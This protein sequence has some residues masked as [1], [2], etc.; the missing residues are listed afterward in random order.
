MRPKKYPYSG[1]RK[2]QTKSANVVTPDLVIFPNISIRKE[3]LKHVYT[4]IKNV[5][6]TTNIYFRIPKPFS[7]DEQRIT[8]NLSYE[9]T[10]E[11]LKN[12]Q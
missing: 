3:M 4:V 7:F 9:E 1:R 12:I 8:V 6:R 2:N 11:M 5:G 10:I